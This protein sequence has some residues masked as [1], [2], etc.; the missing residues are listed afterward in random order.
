VVKAHGLS[1]E[2]VV[3]PE[4]DD[5]RRFARGRFVY[6][7]DGRLLTVR[8][9]KPGGRGW[10]VS[11]EEI[12]DRERAEALVGLELVIDSRDRRLLGSN[13]FWP[14]QLVGLEV[15]DRA[16]HLIGQ[17]TNVDDSS[18]QARLLIAIPGSEVEVPFVDELVPS[19]E[20][21][22]GYLVLDPIPGLFD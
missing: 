13:E 2:V 10:L 8:N 22:Q 20:L 9:N 5:Q 6:T 12:G 7:R 15:R 14:D 21:E 16:G 11:F 4:T 3:I 18:D 1:G 17:V 19:V